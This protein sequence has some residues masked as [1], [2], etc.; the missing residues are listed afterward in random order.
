MIQL[1][2][3]SEGLFLVEAAFQA[4]SEAILTSLGSMQKWQQFTID[5]KLLQFASF[6]SNMR[7]DL[8]LGGLVGIFL[9]VRNNYA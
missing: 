8:R 1:P 6:L 5:D 3:Q 7:K 4:V 2:S 9:L